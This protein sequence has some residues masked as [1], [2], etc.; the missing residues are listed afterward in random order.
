MSREVS[1]DPDITASFVNRYLEDTVKCLNQLC[2]QAEI[3]MMKIWRQL[4]QLEDSLEIVEYKL[5][6]IP[7]LE[8]QLNQLKENSD[9]KP[10]EPSAG[11]SEP[12]TITSTNPPSAENPAK[13]SVEKSADLEVNST[14]EVSSDSATEV[15]AETAVSAPTVSGTKA[16]DHPRYQKYFKM[17]KLGV[18]LQATK[19]KMALEGLDGSVLDTPDLLMLDSQDQV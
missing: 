14:A 4:Q 3:E 5:N 17:L 9:S 10:R 12:T 16:C 19:N 15:P 1:L 6:S 2:T 7:G 18:P 8:T 13:K 11:L